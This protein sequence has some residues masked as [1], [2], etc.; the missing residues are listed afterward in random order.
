MADAPE[1][2]G[3]GGGAGGRTLKARGAWQRGAILVLFSPLSL[4]SPHTLGPSPDRVLSPAAPRPRAASV[5]SAPGCRREGSRQ[6]ASPDRAAAPGLPGR[7]S[8]LRR[9]AV[10]ARRVVGEKS[11]GIA[12]G[13]P[14][15]R[16]DRRAC[17][18]PLPGGCC[19]LSDY[20]RSAARYSTGWATPLLCLAA[21]GARA[22]AAARRRR[23]GLASL[24]P[25]KKSTTAAS[26]SVGADAARS[27]WS[28]SSC[29]SKTTSRCRRVGVREHAGGAV[30]PKPA[31]DRHPARKTGRRSPRPPAPSAR[32]AGRSAAARG[33]AR[34]SGG[35]ERKRRRRART[36]RRRSARSSSRRAAVVA[37]R[38]I[39]SAAAAVA[40]QLLAAATT[41][42]SERAPRSATPR[43]T[44]PDPRKRPLPRQ[45][46]AF[47]LSTRCSPAARTARSTYGTRRAA[48]RRA[49]LRAR[50]RSSPTHSHPPRSWPRRA[51]PE[52][53][54][55]PGTGRRRCRRGGRHLAVRRRAASTAARRRRRLGGFEAREHLAAQPRVA[56]K[57][58][59]VVVAAQSRG[60]RPRASS[61]V[62]ARRDRRRRLPH[63]G[64]VGDVVGDRE[65]RDA[66]HSRAVQRPRFARRVRRAFIAEGWRTTRATSPPPPPGAPC[67]R[68]GESQHGTQ[69]LDDARPHLA[70]VSRRRRLRERQRRPHRRRRLDKPRARPRRRAVEERAVA[71]RDAGERKHRHV[72][73]QVLR[74][75]AAHGVLA[76][77]LRRRVDALRVRRELCPRRLGVVVPPQ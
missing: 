60:E 4:C 32:R 16:V 66:E 67:A 34:G 11:A 58:M 27:S 29:A 76:A 69:P 61:F 51:T 2:P 42:I 38:A 56:R 75:R 37:P 73:E 49:P 39:W 3:G 7:V 30:E 9:E 15:R 59:V 35:A 44:S 74:A 72:V 71:A 36:A 57:R 68:L 65:R 5:R 21:G 33:G 1:E 8:A 77:E 17:S 28:C 10:A 20:T 12:T 22:A 6:H 43:A 63:R 64:G 70:V 23:R 46:P 50:R 14:V 13:Q 41:A 45:T 48:P 24:A 55:T 31:S 54:A 26:R 53:T 25:L 52:G 47:L 18:G 62:E 19:A 40:V